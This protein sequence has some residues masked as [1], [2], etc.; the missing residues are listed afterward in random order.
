MTYQYILKQ[1]IDHFTV[2][3]HL[4][5]TLNYWLLGMGPGKVKKKKKKKKKEKEKE[6][7]NSNLIITIIIGTYFEIKNLFKLILTHFLLLNY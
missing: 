7:K 3:S 1:A 4:Q 2:S 6:K 5:F